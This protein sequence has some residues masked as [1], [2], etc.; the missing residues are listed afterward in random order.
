MHFTFS[1]PT[2]TNVFTSMCLTSSDD[3]L[4]NWKR[5]WSFR[6]TILK[7]IKTALI[8]IQ[9]SWKIS[10]ILWAKE[11]MPLDKHWF[12]L[13]FQHHCLLSTS[14]KKIAIFIN[15]VALGKS[16]SLSTSDFSSIRHGWWFLP[17]FQ[18]I[19]LYEL[20]LISH[21]EQNPAAIFF[22]LFLFW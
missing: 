12:L 5:F 18:N 21:L 15:D 8:L 13:H 11:L 1:F 22:F 14:Q 2:A 19:G 10:I 17:T 3:K 7:Y 6:N 20:I 9:S 16:L 4:T